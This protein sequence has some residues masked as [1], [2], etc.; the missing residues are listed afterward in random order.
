MKLWNV[1][2][3][4]RPFHSKQG[5][6]ARVLVCEWEILLILL[7]LSFSVVYK[8]RYPIENILVLICLSENYDIFAGSFLLKKKLSHMF[9]YVEFWESTHRSAPL[10][11]EAIDALQANNNLTN[12]K[13]DCLRFTSTIHMN[14]VF[15]QVW[16][17]CG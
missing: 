4:H 7:W 17:S 1:F 13:H 12:I 8:I 14:K 2:D 9:T 10:L 6:Q 16:P 11:I 5:L 15:I 3:S